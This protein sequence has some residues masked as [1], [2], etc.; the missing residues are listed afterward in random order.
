MPRGNPNPSPETRFKPGKIANPKGRTS[1]QRQA[2]VR[3]AWLATDI[4]TKL[5][6]RL[7]ASLED[8]AVLAEAVNNIDLLKLLKDA[9]ERGLGSPKANLDLSNSDGTL[10][11]VPTRDAVLAALA[12]K[13][14]GK[15]AT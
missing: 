14:D 5:L 1:E 7:Q 13:H 6:E 10:Q 4:R 11:R 9:E 2:E 15:P 3:N 12:K 8:E